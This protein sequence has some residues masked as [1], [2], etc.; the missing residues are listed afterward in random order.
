MS[1]NVWF[2]LKPP[3]R[4]SSIWRRPP[5]LFYNFLK[6]WH[7]PERFKMNLRMYASCPCNTQSSCRFRGGCMPWMARNLSGLR[8]F[9]SDDKPEKFSPANPWKDL[10]IFIFNLCA[11][12]RSNTSLSLPGDLHK[13]IAHIFDHTNYFRV[14]FVEF[15]RDSSSLSGGSKIFTLV[16]NLPKRIGFWPSICVG[17]L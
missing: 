17:T 2:P 8:C 6:G 11:H 10:A 7:R 13:I 12:M 5:S 16:S 15:F 9:R 4:T 3:D 1:D 14:W